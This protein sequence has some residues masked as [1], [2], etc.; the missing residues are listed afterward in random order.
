MG[1]LRS[2]AGSK[3]PLSSHI[4]FRWPKEQYNNN[5]DNEGL[6]HQN[7]AVVAD[8]PIVPSR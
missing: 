1:W 3:M 8:M 4:S 7:G 6:E 5:D 2:A